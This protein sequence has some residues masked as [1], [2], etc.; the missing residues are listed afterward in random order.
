MRRYA[1]ELR[2]V[3]GDFLIAIYLGGSF[4]TGDFAPGTSDYDLLVIVAGGLTAQRVSRL[5]ALHAELAG[6]DAESLLLE[7]DYVPRDDL[8]PEGTTRP[9]WWFRAGS[10]QPPAFMLSAD[11]IANMRDEGIA[12]IGP[13]APL[14]LPRVTA[15]HVRAA[16]R[17][18]LAEKPEVSNERDAA[19]ELLDI[20]RSLAGLETAR[21]TSHAAGLRW[22][23]EHVDRRWHAVLRRASEVRGGAACDGDDDTLRRALA[24]WR[25][26]LGLRD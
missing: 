24:A 22:A 7:G 17:D 11:N 15:E 16:I 4:A 25:E 23:L 8:V 12:I 21:P 9:A 10:L 26:E 5:R 18:M 6:Q 2:D 14:I 19:K 1:T 20:A 3:L 13:S